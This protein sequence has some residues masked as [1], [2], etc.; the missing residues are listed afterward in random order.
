MQKAVYYGNYRDDYLFADDSGLEVD[1][2]GG[3]PGVHSARY[4]GRRRD[5]CSTTTRCCSSACAASKIARRASC[6]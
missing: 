3:A 4:A 6:A 1:A 5:R 2:L